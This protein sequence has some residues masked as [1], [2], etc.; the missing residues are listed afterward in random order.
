MT[1]ERWMRALGIALGL[2]VAVLLIG[3]T[4]LDNDLSRASRLLVMTIAGITFGWVTIRQGIIAYRYEGWPL[5]LPIAFRWVVCL[6]FG[7]MTLLVLWILGIAVWTHV[8]TTTRSTFIWL[9]F[10]ETTIFFLTRWVAVGR[11]QLAGPGETGV[12]R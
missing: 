5:V 11:P 2:A 6:W 8:Y 12:S 3:D 1:A 9:A 10:A 4:V 7:A